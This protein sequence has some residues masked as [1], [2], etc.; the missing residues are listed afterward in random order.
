MN[1]RS[2]FFTG[3]ALASLAVLLLAMPL[4]LN[5]SS[6]AFA[7]PNAAPTPLAAG[8]TIQG[9]G[10]APVNFFVTRVITQDVAGPPFNLS[11]YEVLDVQHLIDQTDVNTTTL[12]LQFSNDGHNWVDGVNLVTDNTADADALSQ[13]NNFGL[14]TRVYADVSNTNPVTVSAIAVAK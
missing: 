9:M 13:Y 11:L 3:A 5:L 7:A 10:K 4:I 6:T 1:H 14:Y 8:L 12:K 2:V